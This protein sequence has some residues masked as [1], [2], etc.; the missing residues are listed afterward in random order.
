MLDNLKDL[1]TLAYAASPRDTELLIN[2][3]I[4]SF[5]SREQKICDE[6]IRMERESCAYEEVPRHIE[7]ERGKLE[8][9]LE[10]LRE[11]VAMLKNLMS[12]LRI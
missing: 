7:G 11:E 10:V 6:L 1:I 3:R 2:K 4:T 8:S 12:G 9:D 5:S